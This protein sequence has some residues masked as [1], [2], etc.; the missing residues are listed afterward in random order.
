[1]PL[2]RALKSAARSTACNLAIENCATGI[3]MKNVSY[4]TERN[5]LDDVTF[6]HCGVAIHLD[7]T[8][9]AQQV[10][11]STISYGY[12]DFRIWVN[13]YAPGTIFWL[14]GGGT[15]Y[16]G[17]YSVQGKIYPGTTIFDTHSDGHA[18]SMYNN[19]VLVK[20]EDNALSGT[21]YI[22]DS[23]NAGGGNGE[24]HGL[25]QFQVGSLTQWAYPGSVS[26][27]TNNI[28]N[29]PTDLGSFTIVAGSSDVISNSMITPNSRCLAPP[30]SLAAANVMISV[31]ISSITWGQAGLSHPTSHA[32]AVFEVWCHP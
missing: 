10:G 31:F 29:T 19:T 24:I 6:H 8:G 9:H 25:G 16:G 26:L 20:V 7:R 30:S 12:N 15:A 14:S 4:W 5:D 11:N 13:T 22:F 18:N 27:A 32:G 3:D 17:T 28:L 21:S 1:M 2:A 23:H